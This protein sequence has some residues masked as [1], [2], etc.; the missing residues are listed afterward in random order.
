MPRFSFFLILLEEFLVFIVALSPQTYICP[1][2]QQVPKNENYYNL[3]NY[4]YFCLE[5]YCLLKKI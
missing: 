3:G 5:R 1:E 4:Q 2:G